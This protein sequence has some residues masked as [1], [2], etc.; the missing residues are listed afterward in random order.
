MRNFLRVDMTSGVCRLESLPRDLAVFGGRGLASMLIVR[1]MAPEDSMEVN[2]LGSANKLV[3]APG[4]LSETS[5]ASSGRTAIACKSP[6][7]GLIPYANAGGLPGIAL[8]TQSL[9]AIFIE[10]VSRPGSW[11]DLIIDDEGARLASSTVVGANTHEAMASLVRAYGGANAFITIGRAG[12][13]CLPMAGLAFSDRDGLPTR[14]AGGGTGAVMGSKGLKAI[15]V[16][17]SPSGPKMH[18]PTGFAAA[19]KRFAAILGAHKARSGERVT[20]RGCMPSCIL[21][22]HD[23]A[24]G[25]LKSD[26]DMGKWPQYEEM[27]RNASKPDSVD[28]RN[29]TRYAFLCNDLGIDAFAMGVMLARL[30]RQGFLAQGDAVG[31]LDLLDAMSRNPLEA[32]LFELMAESVT[33]NTEKTDGANDNTKGTKRF[34]R[35]HTEE[36]ALMDSLG[37]CLFAAEAL[38]EN[39]NALGT[40]TDMVNAKYGFALARE[41]ILT[42]ART[43]LRAEL[44]FAQQKVWQPLYVDYDILKNI[45]NNIV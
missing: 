28:C 21:N 3:I 23:G 44:A 13:A 36:S 34:Y 37:I 2:P 9:A 1:E 39:G 16:K 43:V 40:L 22:C 6:M 14:H 35:Q 4:L 33:Q 10:G 11:S 24:A 26:G 38:Q 32:R 17:G 27:W 7:D 42:M 30:Q 45:G 18:D 29:L 20:Y 8:A 19:S 31:A 25:R 12:E 15:I 5:C 41:D